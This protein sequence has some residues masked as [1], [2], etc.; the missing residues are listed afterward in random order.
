MGL[1]YL[2]DYLFSSFFL[3]FF[4]SFFKI[5]QHDSCGS[6]IL[7]LRQVE[8]RFLTF[9][10]FSDYADCGQGRQKNKR[11]KHMRCLN[12]GGGQ[13]DWRQGKSARARCCPFC[14]LFF[15]FAAFVSLD[16][17]LPPGKLQC[18]APK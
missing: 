8:L 6:C 1:D 13:A 3:S 15:E 16:L 11:Q 10:L 17:G 12:S 4:L 9:S 7:V 5:L 14:R 18:V 2:F